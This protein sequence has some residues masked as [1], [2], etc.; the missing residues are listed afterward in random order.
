MYI[1]S[2][3]EWNI[4]FD[5]A[6]CSLTFPLVNVKGKTKYAL[7]YQE[8]VSEKFNITFGM[9]TLACRPLIVTLSCFVVTFV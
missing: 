5:I 7:L 1:K 2:S 6:N 3:R 4:S 8:N 9:L